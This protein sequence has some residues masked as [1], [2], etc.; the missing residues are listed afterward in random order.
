MKENLN[1]S[2]NLTTQDLLE[3]LNFLMNSVENRFYTFKLFVSKCLNYNIRRRGRTK[4]ARQNYLHPYQPGG[5]S[6]EFLTMSKISG[7][8]YG[9]PNIQMVHLR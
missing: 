2:I 1:F 3:K 6:S 7:G 5:G 4:S 8:F 9:F